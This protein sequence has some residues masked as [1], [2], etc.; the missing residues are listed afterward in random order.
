MTETDYMP[1]PIVLIPGDTFFHRMH[2]LAKLIWSIGA[3]VLAFATRNPLVL[4]VVFL[5]GLLLFVLSGTWRGYGRFIAI[6]FPIS[7]SL[8][9]FQSIAPAFPPPWTPIAK[10]GPFTLYNEGIYSGLSILARAWAASNIAILMVMTTHPSDL[11][12]A[13]QSI[14]MPYELN[15]ALMASLQLIPIVQREFRI[16]VSAQRSRAMRSHGFAALLPSMVPVFAG[17]IE[18]VRQLSMSL[19]SRGFGTKGEKTSLRKIQAS[20]SDWAVGS[21]GIIVTLLAS[22]FVIYYR[23]ELDWSKVILMPPWLAVTLVIGCAVTFVV[24]TVILMR[25]AGK[26]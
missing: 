19:E 7:L 14:G 12:A 18:R 15:F 5:L 1:I 2:P 17:T 4:G 6:L 25:R 10:I 20:T 24:S 16:V 9:V 23:K 3:V 22:Y 21:L 26:E 11:F 8:M 13:M